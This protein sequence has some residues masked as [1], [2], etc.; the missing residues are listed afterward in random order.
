VKPAVRVGLGILLSRLGGLVRER[1]FAHYFGTSLYADVFRAALRM[2]N[3][4]QNLLGEG[5]L[6]ASFIPVYAELLEKRREEDAGRVAGAILSLL[7]ALAGVLALIGTF[8]APWLVV[9]FL[10]GFTGEK[11]EVATAVTRILFPMTGIL[12]LS[13]WALGVLNSHRRFFLAYVAP[14]F[15]NLVMI[16]VL[17]AWGVRPATRDLTVALSWGALGGG[18]LQFLVQ[19]PQ[20]LKLERHLRLKLDLAFGPVREA[21]R[22]AGPAIVG[23]GVVQLSGWLDLVLASLLATGAVAA[24]GYAQTL[25]LLP[26]S[27]FGMSVAA[28][29]LPE[30]SRQRDTGREVLQ[31]RLNAGLRQ[32]A[33]LV[34]PATVGYLLLGDVIVGALYQTG[35]FQRDETLFVFTV[36]A[37]YALG[38]PASTTT[39]LLSST[40]FAL[41][42]TRTPAWI[43][44]VRVGV[45]AVIGAVLIFPLDRWQVAGHSVGA[46]GLS[47]ASGVGA[48][49]E[50]GLLHRRL[51]V[52]L[53]SIG[54]GLQPTLIM[55]TV[56]S[57]GGGLVRLCLL[58]LPGWHPVLVAAVGLG[59]YV[60]LYLA[61]TFALGF[62]EAKRIVRLGEGLGRV[63]KT[64]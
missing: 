17:L 46:L 34:I 40:F 53:G 7:V 32:I 51:S 41:H 62:E 27:L 47:V 60:G 58:F 20:V 10:P 28:A 38:L 59:L 12:V 8:L 56:A 23:R 36:L 6:S 64:K 35:D 19:L 2:P 61:G 14:V 3:V 48:W 29:E 31:S 44:L 30:L 45:A 9:V 21:L 49:M 52:Q 26:V 63:R 18:L 57:I 55:L 50:W 33:F 24:L 43:A 16:G 54:P 37:G 15:W 11:R 25:Y 22:N 1:I 4:L 13:A 42:D 5:T 39:R